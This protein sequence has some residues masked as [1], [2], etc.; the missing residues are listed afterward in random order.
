MNK[1]IIARLLLICATILFLFNVYNGYINSNYNY[2]NIISNL[3]L[4]ISMV[5]IIFRKKVKK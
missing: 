4:I 1:L 5:I 3:L 2:W